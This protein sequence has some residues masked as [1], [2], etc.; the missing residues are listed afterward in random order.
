MTDYYDPASWDGIAEKNGFV[1]V[2]DVDKSNNYILS[3]SGGRRYL[4]R[5][6]DKDCEHCAGTGQEPDGWTY[7]AACADQKGYRRWVLAVAGVVMTP[8]L[9]SAVDARDFKDG[10]YRCRACHGAGHTWK[11]VEAIEPWPVFRA[12]ERGRLWHVE[13]E[14]RILASGVGLGPCADYDRQRAQAAVEQLVDRVEDALYTSPVPVGADVDAVASD[15]S[16]TIR[17]N[18]AHNGIEVVFTSKP[19][20]EV[21]EALKALGFRWSQRQGLWYTR[22]ADRT[23]QRVHALLEEEAAT[24]EPGAPVQPEPGAEPAEPEAP[25]ETPRYVIEE[26]LTGQVIGGNG[27]DPGE[28][29]PEPWQMTRL[30]YQES[31]AARVAG[32]VPIL[33]ARDGREHEA[34]VRRAAAEGLPVP[35]RVLAEYGLVEADILE[36]VDVYGRPA[37]ISHYDYALGRS[38]LRL[39]CQTAATLL[40]DLPASH[41]ARR[42]QG[43]AVTLHR[44]NIAQVLDRRLAKQSHETSSIDPDLALPRLAAEEVLTWCPEPRVQVAAAAADPLQPALFPTF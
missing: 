12:N 40:A 30:T 25:T 43:G 9:G 29:E 21:R 6:R 39:Y 15:A 20:V 7:E 13:R 10:H 31:R 11:E 17:H 38:Q 35:P 36:V 2:V 42:T 37:R 1:M 26:P 34:A 41:E 18:Q 5:V 24:E 28:T 14:G 27:D 8:V 23:W 44:E 4:E 3:C 32:G 19:A 33:N 22:Y 16:A